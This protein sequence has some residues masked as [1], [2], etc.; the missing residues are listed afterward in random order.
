M[1]CNARSVRIAVTL[2]GTIGVLAVPAFAQTD[3]HPGP[4]L[5]TSG[6]VRTY[7]PVDASLS[8]F[9][10]PDNL[11]V[12]STYRRYVETLADRSPTF[13]RQCLRLAAAPWLTV[14]LAPLPMRR[15]EGIRART[16]F[17]VNG[18]NRR[19]A[20]IEIATLDDQFELIAH[21]IEH[22]IEQL[23]GVDLG[24]RA[25]LPSSG[26][27]RC[28]NGESFETVRAIRAGRLAGVEVRRRRN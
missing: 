24:V 5:A 18:N 26:V 17:L 25:R 9:S 16:Q 12:P 3:M 22:V 10:L 6:V 7:V 27:R 1:I 20:L 8:V 19:I 28:D 4:T 13:R 21:E 11:R 14:M 15:V 23:D 2:T